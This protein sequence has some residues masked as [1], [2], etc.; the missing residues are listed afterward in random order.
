MLRALPERRWDLNLLRNARGSGRD[1]FIVP[2]ATRGL[3]IE[4]DS[5]VSATDRSVKA[6]TQP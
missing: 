4:G 1:V 5:R 6:W 3:F 2:E